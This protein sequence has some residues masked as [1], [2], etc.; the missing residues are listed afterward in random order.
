MEVRN[1]TLERK[2]FPQK[3]I[4]FHFWNQKTKEFT[5]LQKLLIGSLLLFFIVPFIYF[6]VSMITQF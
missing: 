2:D 3:R 1:Y 6:T 5:V 4:K